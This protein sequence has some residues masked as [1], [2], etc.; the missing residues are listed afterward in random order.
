M[1][2]RFC[3]P[4]TL[5]NVFIEVSTVAAYA[6]FVQLEWVEASP[7]LHGHAKQLTNAGIHAL[8]LYYPR[9]FVARSEGKLRPMP[10]VGSAIAG[11]KAVSIDTPT[12]LT[13]AGHPSSSAPDHLRAPAGRQASTTGRGA[14]MA[15]C[16]PA[17]L[18]SPGAGA[19]CTSEGGDSSVGCQRGQAKLAPSYT[20]SGRVSAVCSLGALGPDSHRAQ[21]D[22]CPFAGA[23]MRDHRHACPPGRHA[24]HRSPQPLHHRLQPDPGLPDR[25][26]TCSDRTSWRYRPSPAAVAVLQCTP[27]CGCCTAL[28]SQTTAAGAPGQQLLNE[29]CQQQTQQLQPQ[30]QALPAQHVVA[31]TSQPT[32]RGQ[33]QAA[34][35]PVSAQQAASRLAAGGLLQLT[36]HSHAHHCV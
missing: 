1:Q 23:S 21:L 6:Y 36:P 4:A 22:P 28:R 16:D 34:S 31:P 26:S 19:T 18:P 14:S 3:C 12:C 32:I 33:P 30:L 24:W 5:S 7:Q 17:A 25:A 35:K 20:R 13:S 29:F 8:L 27:P 10:G 2:H 11:E 15:Y 9:K